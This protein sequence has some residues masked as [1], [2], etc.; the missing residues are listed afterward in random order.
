MANFSQQAAQQEDSYN[1]KIRNLKAELETAKGQN[2]ELQTK[3]EE[4]LASLAE[5]QQEVC[6]TLALY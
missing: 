1:V 3:L 5:H 6:Q 4:N 2:E